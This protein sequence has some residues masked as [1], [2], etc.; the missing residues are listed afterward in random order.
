MNRKIKVAILGCG[1]I[2]RKHIEAITINKSKFNLSALCDDNEIK[3]DK[4]KINVIKFS[5]IDKLLSSEIKLDL[6]SICTPSGL[7]KSHA[8]KVLKKRINVLIEKPMAL[9]NK[10]AREII[11]TGL[12]YRT[13]VFI[14]LQNRFNPTIKLL[15]KTL[16]NK[17]LGRIF[18]INLNVLWNRDQGYYD[19]DSWRGTKKMDGGALM[20][21]TIHFIDLLIW[22]FGSTKKIQ[23]IR[24]RLA[25]KIETEDSACINMLFKK[26]ILCSISSTMLVN[27]ENY[28]GSIT[29]IAEK[30]TIKIGGMA[31][32][33]IVKWNI[34]K[35]EMSVKNKKKLNYNLKSVYG[36]GHKHIYQEIYKS[37]NNL[38]S[39]AVMGNDGIMSVKLIDELYKRNNLL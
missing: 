9:T 8:I 22:L 36:S 2:S 16:D 30:G 26:N 4:I 13:K 35:K 23:I 25:R 24:A 7:H 12:K 10:D 33:K 21:Q 6:V 29:I 15:K 39:K 32:N 18:F 5:S 1:R 27:Q 14:C 38:K 34:N 19:Q 31:L 17:K 37:L 11:N 3:L 20:N 28:E